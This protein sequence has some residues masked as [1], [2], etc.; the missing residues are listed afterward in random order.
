MLIPFHD[1]NPTH[2]FP[3]VT[4]G[5]IL[6]NVVI[7]V[8]FSAQDERTQRI[9]TARFGFV[10]EVLS[11][12]NNGQPVKVDLYPDLPD[13][14][15]DDKNRYLEIQPTVSHVGFSLVTS[16][17]MHAGWFHVLGNMLFFW[18]F[19]NNIEDRLG[20]VVFTLFY[21]AGGA[22]ADLCHWLMAQPPYDLMPVVGASGAVAVI[23]GAYAV[24]YPR[25]KV[26]VFVLLG[27]IPLI[28]QIP[29]M[30]VLGLWVLKDIFAVW[31]EHQGF[32]T[33]VA[34]WAHIGGFFTGALVMP[35]LAAG[36]PE[37]GENWE[38]E[39]ESQ[40]D[41]H[42]IDPEQRVRDR[43]AAGAAGIWWDEPSV[44]RPPPGDVPP[45]RQ[46]DDSIWW[47]DEKH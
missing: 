10:P 38:K 36:T 17:F 2:R 7:F 5:I 43:T 39:A 14:D 9:A 47:D 35:L 45:T 29:A 23:L 31:M 15:M 3:Y 40:F 1:D 37:P 34:L 42:S 24:T 11:N 26:R 6:L 33:N 44:R 4:V 28:I 32:V 22:M 19:G 12:V 13:T 25:A 41:Y 30:I 20:H 21:L 27:C 46:G 18:V 8:I 16:M